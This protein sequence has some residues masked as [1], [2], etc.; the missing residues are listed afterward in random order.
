[1]PV[2]KTVLP[3]GRVRVSTPGGVKAKSASKENAAKLERL[4]NAVDH[5]WKPTGKRTPKP[6]R[7][8]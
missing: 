4:L 5:G 7:M 2:T 3:S 6:K 8:M 1:M